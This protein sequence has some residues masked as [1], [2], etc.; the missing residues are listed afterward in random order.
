[1]VL[2]ASEAYADLS[3]GAG[4]SIE[5]GY[6]QILGSNN[7]MVTA[8]VSHGFIE[9]SGADTRGHIAW[10]GEPP[11]PLREREL[12]GNLGQYDVSG[13]SYTARGFGDGAVVTASGSSA[14]CFAIFVGQVAKAKTFHCD[15]T[16][17]GRNVPQ[18]RFIHD[19]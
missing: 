18:P 10:V 17:L 5:G 9:L 19:R 15:L 6:V 14:L 16:K 12:R 1:M 2:R 3:E 13:A 4:L 8:S 11:L 7:N